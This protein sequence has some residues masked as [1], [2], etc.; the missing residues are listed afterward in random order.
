MTIRELIEMLEKERLDNEVVFL[1]GP[2]YND[3][4]EVAKIQSDE[5]SRV[6]GIYLGS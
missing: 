1:T 4:Y 5:K 3:E 6:T 2:D